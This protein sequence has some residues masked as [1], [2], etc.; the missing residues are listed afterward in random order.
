MPTWTIKDTKAL[1]FLTRVPH[2]PPVHGLRVVVGKRGA[3]DKGPDQQPVRHTRNELSYAPHDSSLRTATRP[4]I[5]TSG[6]YG[7]PAH[8]RIESNL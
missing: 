8:E 2:E 5:R 1:R 4:E 6:V 3:A 7:E